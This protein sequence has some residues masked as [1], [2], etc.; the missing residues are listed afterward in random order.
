MTALALISGALFKEAETKIARASG[1]P[2]VVA[3]L[4]VAADNALDFWRI[5]AF[6]ETAQAELLRLGE[7]DKLSAQGSLKLEIYSSKD[8]EQKLSRTLIADH[9]L[10]LRPPPRARKPKVA[11]ATAADGPA[12]P[13]PREPAPFDDAI[14]WGGPEQ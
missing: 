10:A 14:P 5:V 2:F 3:K 8:G 1:K 11:P 6:S 13:G 7:G 9:V 4:K 12:A